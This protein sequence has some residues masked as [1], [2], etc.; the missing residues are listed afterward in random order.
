MLKGIDSIRPQV[1]FLELIATIMR[2]AGS[3]PN[4]SFGRQL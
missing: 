4:I 2:R 1:G 3:L